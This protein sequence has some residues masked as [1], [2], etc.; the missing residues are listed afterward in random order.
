VF[1]G[2]LSVGPLHPSVD[3]LPCVG[4]HID[5]LA[6]GL[7]DDRVS[8]VVAAVVMGDRDIDDA[9]D[10]F[11]DVQDLRLLIRGP[12]HAKVANPLYREVLL[13]ELTFSRQENLPRP[14]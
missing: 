11:D 14:W 10:D 2:I 8:K 6:H 4:A 3:G 13:R 7:R 1:P 12:D 5:A 9:N